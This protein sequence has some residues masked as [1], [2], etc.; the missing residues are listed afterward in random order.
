LKGRGRALGEATG[1]M[2]QEE[3][4]TWRSRSIG[5][6]SRRRERRNGEL[7][8]RSEARE[9]VRPWAAED[10]ESSQV[11]RVFVLYVGFVIQWP[12]NNTRHPMVAR[13]RATIVPACYMCR[14]WADRLVICVVP[15]P[16]LRADMA[17]QA[18]RPGRARHGVMWA[19]TCCAWAGPSCPP[20]LAKYSDLSPQQWI[21]RLPNSFSVHQLLV[22]SVVVSSDSEELNR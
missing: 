13:Y 17:A 6:G 14:A 9:G 1:G 7:Q 5:W 12:R 19:R 20:Q 21:S 10:R 18:I 22:E 15:G 4:A 11:L 2:S 8:S 16:A 3:A